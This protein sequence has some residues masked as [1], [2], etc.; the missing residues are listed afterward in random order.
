MPTHW[1]FSTRYTNEEE[2][3][4][5]SRVTGDEIRTYYL[6]AKPK[7]PSLKLKHF[8]YLKKKSLELRTVLK[9]TRPLFFGLEEKFWTGSTINVV[10]YY[11]IL[12][13]RS[14]PIENWRQCWQRGFVSSVT[15]LGSVFSAIQKLFWTSL[16]GTW[17]RRKKSP[18]VWN[19]WQTLVRL[20]YINS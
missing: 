7:Q 3:F 1:E 5:Y 16:V 18:N 9:K 8:H 2:V 19:V 14:R 4:F 6:I 12:K 17:Y 10:S 13:K 11:E 15:K 20:P